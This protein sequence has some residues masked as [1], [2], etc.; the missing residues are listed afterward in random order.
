MRWTGDFQ[1][2]IN[3]IQAKRKKKSGD[4]KW[5]ML[6][7][8]VCRTVGNAEFIEEIGCTCFG[9]DKRSIRQIFTFIILGNNLKFI[10]MNIAPRDFKK[11]GF[12]IFYLQ[13]FHSSFGFHGTFRRVGL[14]SFFRQKKDE[15]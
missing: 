4:M 6:I 12:T 13:S 9:H 10:I 15:R 5:I 11:M 8:L 2:F 14:N 7:Q 1:H 3:K